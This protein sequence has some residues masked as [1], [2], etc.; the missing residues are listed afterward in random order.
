MVSQLQFIILKFTHRT[1]QMISFKDL[2]E[3]HQSREIRHLRLSK[4]LHD[5]TWTPDVEKDAAHIIDYVRGSKNL[6]RALIDGDEL[7][8]ASERTHKT[9]LKHS[10]PIGHETILY[11]GSAHDFGKMA[12]ESKDG[13]IHSPAHISATHDFSVAH[14]FVG[15]RNMKKD[16]RENHVIKLTT[17]PEDK[18]LHIGR[19][20]G[21]HSEKETIIPAGT[22]LKY[23]GTHVKNMMS[24]Y[25]QKED[26]HIHHFTIHSQE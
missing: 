16:D 20:V 18:G 12:R 23:H 21:E 19:S 17:K 22:K 2:V 13:I 7:D 26:F 25:G 3:S 6:N 4:K 15:I 9:I 11:S 8:T 5:A 1:E 14:A 24:S 10:K